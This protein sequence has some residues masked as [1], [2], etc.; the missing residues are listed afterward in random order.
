[1]RQWLSL[2]TLLFLLAAS[3]PAWAENEEY[4]KVTAPEV[5]DLLERGR[6]T[7]VHVLSRI[8]YEMQHIPGSINIPITEMHTTDRLPK[9]K[10][11]PLI[12]YCMGLK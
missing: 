3:G 6:A 2:G 1:M 11:A 5:K 9:Q 12:F 8:E 10:D 4:E 7:V